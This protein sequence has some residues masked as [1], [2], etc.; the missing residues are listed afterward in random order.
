MSMTSSKS[1]V[2]ILVTVSA[3]VVLVL[4]VA[5]QQ[6]ERVITQGALGDK[7][8]PPAT[9]AAEGKY[10]DRDGKLLS[11]TTSDDRGR[12]LRC[13]AGDMEYIYTYDDGDGYRLKTTTTRRK[14]RLISKSYGRD[15]FVGYVLRRRRYTE[16]S[17]RNGKPHKFDTTIYVNH[18]DGDW[19][20]MRSGIVNQKGVADFLKSTKRK[21]GVRRDAPGQASYL[22][23]LKKAPDKYLH[24]V[25]FVLCPSY[26]NTR[27]PH[28]YL[29]WNKRYRPNEV[30]KKRQFLGNP[31]YPAELRDPRASLLDEDQW[32]AKYNTWEY[33]RRDQP[34]GERGRSRG[35]IARTV[36]FCS[37]MGIYL[38][39]VEQVMD[40]KARPRPKIK[41]YEITHWVWSRPGGYRRRSPSECRD[42]RVKVEDVRTGDPAFRGQWIRAVYP[43]DPA[44]PALVLP[45][46][47]ERAKRAKADPMTPEEKLLR[48]ERLARCND[49]L[50]H[51]GGGI[52]RC[53]QILDEFPKSW[54]A[55]YA[56]KRLAEYGLE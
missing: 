1:V 2:R 44:T 34:V 41:R 31:D 52:M 47:A 30:S 24:K 40:Y 39:E 20:G 38:I 19:A 54:A 50:T 16:V 48:L 17:Y 12:P 5:A 3:M 27:G 45:A 55:G 22:D 15:I 14:G 37:I 13:V 56:R 26:D 43:S 9:L 51:P 42:Y 23:D 49:S 35:G 53:K 29:K 21:S 32:L 7:S 11:S 8:G 28:T 25:A 10:Y 46:G 33:C 18:P 36:A 6:G 4:S